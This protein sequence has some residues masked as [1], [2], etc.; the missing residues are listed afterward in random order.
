MVVSVDWPGA[1]SDEVKRQVADRIEEKLQEP[2]YLD[3]LKTYCLPGRAVITVQ[4]RNDT[5][6]KA[7]PDLWYQ[8]RKKVGDI[9]HTFPE[10][11]IG[12][13]LDAEYG[14]VDVAADSFPVHDYTRAELKQLQQASPR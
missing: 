14:D 1:T 5:P 8:V 13:F 6:P 3:Y 9:K 2:P 10:G 12:P 7:V 11:V 4:L